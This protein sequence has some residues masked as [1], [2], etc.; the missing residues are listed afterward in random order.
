MYLHY[1]YY[2]S[3]NVLDSLKMY[4][5]SSEPNGSITE[6]NEVWEKFRQTQQW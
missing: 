4:Q 6:L 5:T 3:A 2:L 1:Y